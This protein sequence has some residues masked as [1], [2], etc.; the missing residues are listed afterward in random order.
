MIRSFRSKGLAQFAA[1]GNA[2]KL[3]VQN[4]ARVRRVLVALDAATEPKAMDTPGLKF[5][6]LKGAEKGRFSVWI[7]GNFRITFGWDGKDATDVDLEDYH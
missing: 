3:R 6:P 7:S 2:A 5:H 4:S 1:T